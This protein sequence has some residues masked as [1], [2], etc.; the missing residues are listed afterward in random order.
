MRLRNITSNDYAYVITVLDEWWGGRHVTD[1]L[2]RL[3]FE[4]FADTGFVAESD[5][6]EI[7]G[8]LVGFVSQSCPDQAYVHFVGVHPKHRKSGI[9]KLLYERFFEEVKRRGCR[10]VK[11]VT[12]PANKLSIAFHLRMSFVPSPSESLTEDRVPY[13]LDYDGP[14]LPRVVFSRQ[15]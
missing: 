10:I 5:G 14:T 15:I 1:M 2:P 11:C 3:F 7:V 12:S 13:I 9:G 4:H 6:G 8:F